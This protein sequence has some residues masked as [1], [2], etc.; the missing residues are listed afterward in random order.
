VGQAVAKVL[1]IE[2]FIEEGKFVHYSARDIYTRRANAPGE[3]MWFQN[4]MDI[5]HNSGAAFE[6]LMPSQ[7]LGEGPMNDSSDRTPL[8]ELSAKIGRGGNYI[9]LPINIDAIA[10]KIETEGKAVVLGV[11]FGP[12]E[13]DRA[14]P[15]ILGTDTRY[16][17]GI[18]ATNATLYQGKKALITEDSWGTNSGNGGRRIVTQ[19][20]FNSGR[21]SFAG[22]FTY[23][24]NDGM[25]E[26]NKPHYQFRN[27]LSYGMR[28]NP[29]VVKLQE[30]LSYLKYFPSSVD[31]TGNFLGITLK[32]V[33]D[34]QKAYGITPVSGLVGPVTRAKLNE[35]FL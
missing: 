16:G 29:E 9:N 31:F 4:A 30:C 11:R 35:L 22:Y 28:K 17:H 7:G 21:I 34:F 13:W 2:N 8:V 10:S 20:W 1:G 15:Q 24:K 12:N 14:V 26:T 27:N 33:K 18:A 23:L 19:D 32:A 5:G 6:Q 3:G 25:P